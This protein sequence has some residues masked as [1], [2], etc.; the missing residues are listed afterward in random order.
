MFLPDPGLIVTVLALAI[1]AGALFVL[2][3]RP[4]TTVSPA[5]SPPTQ[6]LGPAFALVRSGGRIVPIDAKF[7]NESY[8]QIGSA[9]DDGDRRARRRA[10]L[11]Q[12]RRH[13]DAVSRYISPDD[14][15]I[16]FAFMYVPSEAIYYELTLAEG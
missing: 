15:S 9:R 12:V 8:T 2:A 1:A 13:V 10:F 7:P 14:G 6:D 5:P 3:R 11:Q 4:A 16:D